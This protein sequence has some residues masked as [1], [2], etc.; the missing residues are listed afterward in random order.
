MY[1]IFAIGR[2]L[3]G[4]VRSIFNVPLSY[5]DTCIE[6]NV[7]IMVYFTSMHKL[8]FVIFCCASLKRKWITTCGHCFQVLPV[9]F[10]QISK[11]C[12]INCSL[13]EESLNIFLPGALQTISCWRKGC[14]LDI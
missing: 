8:V 13:S 3:K 14:V 4:T 11:T 5:L 1:S 12:F 6:G 10:G 7:K 2:N 9:N